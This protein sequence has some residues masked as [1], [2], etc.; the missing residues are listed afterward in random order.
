MAGDFARFPAVP[1][2]VGTPLAIG[3]AYTRGAHNW[4]KTK[5][6]RQLNFKETAERAELMTVNELRSARKDCMEAAKAMDV[7]ERA[8]IRVDKDGGYYIDESGVYGAEMRKRGRAML[9]AA[10]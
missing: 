4:R 8:N 9:K 5:M 10:K 1:W 3:T 2:R 7:L 6:A